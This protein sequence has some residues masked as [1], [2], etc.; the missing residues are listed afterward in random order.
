MKHR[1]VM[2]IVREVELTCKV[3]LKKYRWYRDSGGK[4]DPNIIERNFKVYLS[5]ILDMYNGEIVSYEMSERPVLTP[6]LSCWIKH[7]RTG[8]I[9]KAASYIQIKA[10]STS[11]ALIK[12]H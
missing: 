8:H 6:V 2:R 11:I 3:H 9:E 7:L 1:V 10:G 12:K 4:I 5:P